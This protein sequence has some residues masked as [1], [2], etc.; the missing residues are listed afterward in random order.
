MSLYRFQ[1]G[2]PILLKRG[3]WDQKVHNMSKFRCHA[4]KNMKL[5]SSQKAPS[6]YKYAQGQRPVPLL[7]RSSATVH[8]N[9]NKVRLLPI[10]LCRPH[11]SYWYQPKV[12]L[13]SFCSSL[14]CLRWLVDIKG[15]SDW[16]Q[17]NEHMHR[18]LQKILPMY[19]KSVNFGW[20]EDVHFCYFSLTLP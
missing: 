17:N 9:S 11:W 4:C 20:T 10:I 16:F 6:I 5:V 13:Y 8:G 19:K 2:S 3:N 7:P 18:S 15:C 14:G 1:Q 12:K